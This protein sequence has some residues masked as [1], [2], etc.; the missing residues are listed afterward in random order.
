MSFE[1]VKLATPPRICS[2]ALA[3]TV[4]NT[5]VLFRLSS[6]LAKECKA[7]RG[8]LYA[9]GYDAEARLLALVEDAE[10]KCGYAAKV[11]T[12]K[13]VKSGRAII[14]F[15]RVDLLARI[16]PEP[17]GIR[18]LKLFEK[19]GPGKIVFWIPEAT[20]KAAGKEQS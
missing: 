18:G 12:D 6:E 20:A 7:T 4:R 11:L 19:R 13:S 8:K 14:E 15:P 3:V 17:A 16:F 5:K 10:N 9:L 2:S 1:I